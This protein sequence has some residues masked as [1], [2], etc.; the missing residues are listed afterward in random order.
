M[1]DHNKGSGGDSKR[2]DSPTSKRTP[3]NG[4][5]TLAE[6]LSEHE[7]A[8]EDNLAELDRAL[9]KLCEAAVIEQATQPPSRPVR[10]NGSKPPAGPTVRN[11]SPVTADQVRPAASAPAEEPQAQRV[12]VKEPAA[13]PEGM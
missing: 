9:A 13:R 10:S 1:S 7:A 2:V 11:P 4:T 3:A 5:K 12:E 8:I 6:A